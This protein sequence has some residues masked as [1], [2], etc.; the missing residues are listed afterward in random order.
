MTYC[1]EN[2]TKLEEHLDK[3]KELALEVYDILSITE[4][5]VNLLQH[6]EVYEVELNEAIHKH[7]EVIRKH[8]DYHECT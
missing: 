5:E 3:V 8:G 4:S 6:L 7:Y 1:N 2:L